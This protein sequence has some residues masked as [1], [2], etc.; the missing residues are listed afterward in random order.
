M[1]KDAY[2]AKNQQ[3]MQFLDKWKLNSASAI[4]SYFE[5][6]YFLKLVSKKPGFHQQWQ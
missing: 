4:W 2:K 5:I 6:M 3:N 1:Q